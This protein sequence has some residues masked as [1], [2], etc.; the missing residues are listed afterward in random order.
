MSRLAVARFAVIVVALPDP[1]R[2]AWPR[3]ALL[4]GAG[5]LAGVIAQRGAPRRS[6]HQLGGGVDDEAVGAGVVPVVGVVGVTVGVGVTGVVGVTVGLAVT[7]AVGVTAGVVR[8]GVGVGVA[9]VAGSMRTS[10]ATW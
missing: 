7:V 1:P 6:A 8:V 9:V 2:R 5:R 10:L 4:R 3:A